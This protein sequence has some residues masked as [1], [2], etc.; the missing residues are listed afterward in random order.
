MRECRL[1]VGGK[2]WSRRIEDTAEERSV[3]RRKESGIDETGHRSEPTDK[4]GR[5]SNPTENERRSGSD[6]GGERLLLTAKLKCH[7]SLT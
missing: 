7:F 4:T 5:R 3:S 2:K 1:Y 6:A